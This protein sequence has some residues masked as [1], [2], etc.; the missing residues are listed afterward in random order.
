[1]SAPSTPPSLLKSAAQGGQGLV[2]ISP[3]RARSERA[4]QPET[5]SLK[6]MRTFVAPKGLLRGMETSSSAAVGLEAAFHDRTLV[7]GPLL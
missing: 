5:P 6:R 4:H 1:M 2:P 7:K 3:V